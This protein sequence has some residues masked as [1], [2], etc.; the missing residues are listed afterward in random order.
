[1][2]NFWAS[3][4]ESHQL[5]ARSCAAA[6]WRIPLPRF[7]MAYDFTTSPLIRQ[8]FCHF[9]NPLPIC[10]PTRP[11]LPLHPATLPLRP[12]L[13]HSFFFSPPSAFLFVIISQ[14][15]LLTVSIPRASGSYPQGVGSLALHRPLQTCIAP[16]APPFSLSL[17]PSPFLCSG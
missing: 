15:I 11:K 3:W 12:H 10:P 16:H 4:T 1:M 5:C 8:H 7:V 14:L 2:R 9:T 17:P 6:S 13:A